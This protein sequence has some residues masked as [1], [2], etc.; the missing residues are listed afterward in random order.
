MKVAPK[1]VHTFSRGSDGAFGKDITQWVARFN[2]YKTLVPN[3]RKDKIRN[4]MDMNTLYGGFVVALIDD[5][6]WVMKVVSS[7][8]LNSL[9]DV[10]DRG[11]VGT[12]NDW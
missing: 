4:I 12:Y 9:N 1:W 7:Y 8:H 11:L 2:H 3:P 6:L 10:Y 5:P